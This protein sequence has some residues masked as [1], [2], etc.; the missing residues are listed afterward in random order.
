MKVSPDRLSSRILRALLLLHL[1]QHRIHHCQQADGDGADDERYD[2]I[3]RFQEITADRDRYRE[4]S[5]RNL[6]RALKAE[7]KLATLQGSIDGGDTGKKV[8]TK[9]LGFNR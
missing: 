2:K 7:A 8:D 4:D 9:D 1:C 6:D 3:P 5:E